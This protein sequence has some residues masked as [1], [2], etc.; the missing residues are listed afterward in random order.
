L[1]IGGVANITYIDDKH[2]MAF[3]T[4]PGNALMDDWVKS[5]TGEDYDLDGMLAAVGNIIEPVIKDWMLHPYFKQKPPKS[6]DRDEWDIAEFGRIVRDIDQ[7]E[8]ADGCATLLEFTAQTIIKAAEH[9]PQNP[10]ARE[11]K[12]YVCG[13]GRH[14]EAL[15]KR[16]AEDIPIKKAEDLGWNGD[17]TEAECFGYRAVRSLLK[18][19]ISVPTTT[20]V[21]HPEVG[22]ICHS[23]K[24]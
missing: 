4:G 7:I 12:W 6:L 3:D 10:M 2:I 18:A 17:A 8:T 9:C 11:I 1:N 5:R 20:G 14:N 13:G 21:K 15:M 19:P 24:S 22:G 16:L 23:A